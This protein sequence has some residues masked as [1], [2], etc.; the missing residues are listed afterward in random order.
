MKKKE[1]KNTSP[2]ESVKLIRAKQALS[3]GM[4]LQ[5]RTLYQPRIARVVW[6]EK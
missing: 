3:A 5:W 1:K 4:S 2:W 6:N